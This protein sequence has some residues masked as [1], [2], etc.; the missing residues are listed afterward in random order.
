MPRAP[1]IAVGGYGRGELFPYSDVDLLIL[2]P[3]EPDESEREALEQ[4]V[5]M[6]WDIGLEVGHSVRTLDECSEA[7]AA[8]ITVQTTLLEARY[9]AGS[10]ALFRDLERRFGRA[11]DP[12]RLL[13]GEAARAA[14]APCA[15]Q[16]T[17]YTLEPNIKESARRAARPADDPVDRARSRHDSGAGATWRDLATPRPHR[18]RRSA[19]ARSP[20]A[21][22]RTCASACTTS[23][24]GARTACSSTTRPRSP[25]SSAYE[26]TPHR[27]A[28]EALMQRYY[29]AAKAV[30]QLNTILLQNLEA[31]CAPAID[32]EPQPLNERFRVRG[33]LLEV[34][35]E[36]CSS[37]SRARCSRASSCCSS[38]TS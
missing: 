27:R 26:D 25:R 13:Q 34:A 3:Q 20:R 8:D 36:R 21:A 30:T 18:A 15:H 23:P 5:G 22:S 16:D 28:S 19:A 2:L 17:P 7:A 14:A 6:L 32:S 11:A 4:L 31:R 12:A 35:D 38:T 37:A 9:L 29:R 1:L 24:A 10:R 33:E